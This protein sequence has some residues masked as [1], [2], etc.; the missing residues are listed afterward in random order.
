MIVSLLSFNF[1]RIPTSK[2]KLKLKYGGY[3]RL[4]KNSCRQIYCFGF[5][6][7]IH[8]DITLYKLSQLHEEVIKR[9]SSKNN[10]KFSILYVDKYAPDKSFNELDS[11][12]KFMAMLSIDE[13]HDE[14]DADLCP[15]E[16]SYHSH[17]SSDNEDVLMNDD[18]EVYSFSKNSIGMEVDSKIENVVD[19][20]RDLNHFAK[21][22][23]TRFTKRCENLEC[24][25]IIH[26]YITQDEVT[27]K[28]SVYVKKTVEVHTC[29]RSNKGGNKRATQ[30]W[31][32]NL[33]TNK[34]KS[35]G[36]VAPYELRNWI[37]K[38]YNVDVSYLKVF[39][40][41]EQAYIDMYGSVVEIEFD[42][43]GGNKIFK[44]F[45][46][47]LATSSRG[48][49]AG[50]RP[51]IGLDA[52]HLKEKFNGGL[53]AGTGIDGNNSI[54]PI[55]YC[56][57]QS[58]NP[59]SWTWFLDSLKKSI[60]TQNGLE[61]AIMNV[62]PNVEH[63]ECIR[64]LYSNFKKHF[65]GDFF[66]T[67]LLAAAKT[68][69]PT[70]HERLLKEISDKN[71]VAIAYLNTNQKKFGVEESLELFP[72]VIAS[73]IIFQKHLIIGLTMK[74]FGKKRNWGNTWNGILVP[75]AKSYLNDIAK[76]LGEYEVSRICENQVE[77]NL[78]DDTSVRDVVSMDTVKKHVKIQHLKVSIKVKQP[79]LKGYLNLHFFSVNDNTNNENN[80]FIHFRKHGNNTKSHGDL[81]VSGSTKKARA[82]SWS[83]DN[84]VSLSCKCS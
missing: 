57:L 5:Q 22:D 53:A 84:F 13:P 42:K 52:C 28:V 19:F 82:I 30:G 54:F 51:Y 66:N 71:E 23:P 73:L 29:T 75:I 83:F 44:R 78:K 74:W 17:L 21:S 15:S 81:G 58:E 24:E 20:M 59:Q 33:V 68:Y 12:E 41:K 27:F 55:S 8:I 45:F 38:N 10:P 1:R 18:D 4:T 67:K 70:N 56:M 43:V 65:C 34:L 36:D 25:W 50:C 2:F 39:R 9:Y 40:G 26:A 48:F 47:C 11:D 64:H 72:N 80:F 14:Y 16:K 46:I 60:G 76:N 62:Y 79:P 63:R 31:I 6:K 32:A 61:V 77:G 49:V 35:D 3:F 37:M 69:C 7:C